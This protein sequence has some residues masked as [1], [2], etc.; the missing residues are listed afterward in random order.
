MHKCHRDFSIRISSATDVFWLQ[1]LSPFHQP[2][3][4]HNHLSRAALGGDR[5][6]IANTLPDKIPSICTCFVRSIF[7]RNS[8]CNLP[9]KGTCYQKIGS[10]LMWRLQYILYITVIQV[11]THRKYQ[12]LWRCNWLW[13]LCHG[14]IGCGGNVMV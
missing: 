8:R 14:V 13:W 10:F 11:I 4:Q 3:A 2:I 9:E 5:P 6:N 7:W 1:K 12:W